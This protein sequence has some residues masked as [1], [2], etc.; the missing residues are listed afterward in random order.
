MDGEI[1]RQPEKAE[2]ATTLCAQCDK[3]EMQCTCEK[4]CC[5]CQSQHDIRLAVDRMY[6]C[7]E[8]REACDVTLADKDEH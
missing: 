8:C 1:H 4:F 2:M 5:F 3:P 6:Y 7:P